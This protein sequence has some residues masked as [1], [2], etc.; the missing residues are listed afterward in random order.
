MQRS[1]RERAIDPGDQREATDSGESRRSPRGW[2]FLAAFAAGFAITG[3]EMALGRL[4]APYF[5][6]SLTVW[7]AIIASIIGALSIGYPLGGWL[8]DR[9]PGPLLPLA[10]LLVGGL[11]GSAMGV[12]V[13]HWLRTA[14]AGVG[15]T[16]FAFWGR[17]AFVLLMFGVPCVMLAAVAPSVLRATIRDRTTAGRDAGGLYALGSLGSVLGILLPAL[18]WIPLLGLRMTFLLLGA[19]SVIPAALGLLAHFGSRQRRSVIL[20]ALFFAA[21]FAV[22]EALRLPE[23]E[24]SRVLYDRDSGL[25]R[26]RVVADDSDSHRRRWL[27][28]NEGWSVH[29]W[30]IEP[31]YATDDVWDWMALTSLLPEPDDGRT[32][33]P[34]GSSGPAL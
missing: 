12:A 18:W 21:L 10:T 11:I 16:G 22:P 33:P 5:G 13:P 34:C 28:L 2:L 6:S 3:I 27:Q 32:G 8:A 19:A 23:E 4:L 15:F 7:A 26:I 1:D 14:L 24:G 20:A 25:Q 31:D 17:L 9:K 30:L 29:S